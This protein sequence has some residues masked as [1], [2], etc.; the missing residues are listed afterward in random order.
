MLMTPRVSKI[1]EAKLGAIEMRMETT[2]YGLNYNL[3]QIFF[4]SI[5][6]IVE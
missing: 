6:T 4:I 5:N 1:S 3:D 2:R